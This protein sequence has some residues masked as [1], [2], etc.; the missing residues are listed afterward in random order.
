MDAKQR[1]LSKNYSSWIIKLRNS[2]FEKI[3]KIRKKIG[4][5]RADFL[6]NLV[7]KEYNVEFEEKGEFKT[8]KTN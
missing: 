1:Y 2:D 6:K 8:K 5:S 7:S 4:L 3:E